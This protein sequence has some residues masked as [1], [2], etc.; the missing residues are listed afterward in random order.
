MKSSCHHKPVFAKNTYKAFEQALNESIK[1]VI[2][3]KKMQKDIFDNP[4]QFFYIIKGLGHS[5]EL[6]TY[7]YPFLTVELYEN[8]IE[9]ANLFANIFLEYMNV[10]KFVTFKQMQLMY[11]IVKITHAV[12]LEPVY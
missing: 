6:I 2:A 3:D 5:S 10:N 11:E 4:A 9:F 7:H 12:M 8:M 1:E